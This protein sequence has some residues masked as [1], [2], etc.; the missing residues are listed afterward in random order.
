MVVMPFRKAPEVGTLEGIQVLR[1]AYSRA[2]KGKRG[3]LEDWRFLR[4]KSRERRWGQARRVRSGRIKQCRSRY[5]TDDAVAVNRQA[6]QIGF[7]H[8]WNNLR[9]HVDALIHP[10]PGEA[11]RKVIRAVIVQKLTIAC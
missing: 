5:G 6:H 7:D 9:W 11:Q 1:I 4:T 10:T 3:R 2:A 8:N